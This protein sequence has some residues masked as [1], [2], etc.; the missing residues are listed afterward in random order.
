MDY[1]RQVLAA[2]GVTP[3]RSSGQNFLTCEEIVEAT[4]LAL[5][6]GPR[7][8]TELG[9]GVGTLT[10]ALVSSGFSVRAIERD[11]TLAR[12]LE[13]QLPKKL[14]DHVE[15]VT[16]DLREVD[17]PFD[18]AQG[19]AYSL[20]GNIPYNLS[21]WI[22]RRITQLSPAPE[23]VVLL[24]QQEVADRL[25]ASPP[26]MNMLGLAAQ[27]WGT[28]QRLMSVPASCFWPAPEVQSSLV[29]LAPHLDSE[30]SSG[31]REKILQFAKQFF[32]MKRKQM[33]GV[34]KRVYGVQDEEARKWLAAAG[35]RPE[36]R[37]QELSVEAWKRLAQTVIKAIL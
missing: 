13:K 32:Q 37:P 11:K 30:A 9:S 15:I 8:V 25:V 7:L 19:K 3:Q 29:F 21:G 5:T 34:M 1:L 23:R 22:I 6:G 26:H 17:W 33:G 12:I 14:R 18:S 10:Q 20:V 24:L 28:V 16:D 27:L 36:S 2:H 35:E 4:L 31:E